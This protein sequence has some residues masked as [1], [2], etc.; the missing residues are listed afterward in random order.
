LNN[1]EWRVD[2]SLILIKPE[3]LL[4]KKICEFDSLRY[5]Q[6]CKLIKDGREKERL[7]NDESSCQWHAMAFVKTSFFRGRLQRRARL[8]RGHIKPNPATPIQA[9]ST[10]AWS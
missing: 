5:R 1:L 7:L 10:T 4:F 2:R 3:L 8:S 9:G 6:K